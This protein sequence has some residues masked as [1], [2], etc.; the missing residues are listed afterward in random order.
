MSQES[1]HGRYPGRL[2]LSP[3]LWAGAA[4]LA[5]GTLTCQAAPPGAWPKYTFT[6]EDSSVPE[7]VGVINAKIEARWEENKVTPSRYATDYE[8]IRRASLDI[9]GRIATPEEIRRFLKDPAD[10]RRAKLIDRLLESPEYSRH[11]ANVW[12]NWLL[13]RSGPFGRGTYKDQMVGWLAGQFRKNRPYSEIVSELITAK[14]TN[15]ENG[16]VNFV[17]AHVGDPVPAADRARYGQFQMV[18]LT[19]RITRLF[20]GT[21]VQCA[22]CHD[23]PFLGTVKQEHFWGVNAFLRQVVREGTPPTRRRDMAGPLTLKDNPSANRRAMVSFEKRNGV[24]LATRAV[25][26]PDFRDEESKGQKLDTSPDAPG[27]REQLARY[28]LDHPNFGRAW[29]NRMWSVFLGRGF[30]H[31]MDDFNENNESSHPELLNDL[32]AK[33]KHYNYDQKR[34]IRWICNSLP[35]N[36]SPVA[37]RTNDKSDQERLFSRMIVK[38][39]SPEQLFDS[40][41]VATEGKAVD[42]KKTATERARWLDGLI[43]N[44]GDDEGNEVNFNGTVVQALMMMNGEDINRA[45]SREKEGA[46][47]M[48]MTRN[49]TANGVID[50][51]YL[52]ALNRPATDREKALIR[53]KMQL[54][55][56][57][58]RK[59]SGRAQCDDLY[60]ALLN[61]NEFLLNH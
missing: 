49:R 40:L 28:V 48:A 52:S 57:F 60:W 33:A 43:G 22:Q 56:P 24:L 8:F 42:P 16:A 37:N 50:E 34:L 32:A 59:D 61:S 55:F 41:Q 23:H 27:R 46:V 10:S 38:A 25:F 2:T 4:L 11:W 31:P 18:P 6:A 54:R 26:L 12:A 15:T 1:T 3:V 30:V 17:L 51:L 9:V 44:F 20:L 5:L 35:Y 45:I 21:Q 47:A 13:T 14:G 19:S 58:S 7:M 53:R 39:I 29:V 36:L